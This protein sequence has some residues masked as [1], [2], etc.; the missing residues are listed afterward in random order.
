M[1]RHKQRQ[2]DSVRPKESET[3]TR[4]QRQADI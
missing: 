1:V 4:T 3:D 2:T